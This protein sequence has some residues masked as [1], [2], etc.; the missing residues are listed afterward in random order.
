MRKLLNLAL[1]ALTIAAIFYCI[2]LGALYFE[3]RTYEQTYNRM[4][5]HG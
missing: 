5:H 2:L 1:A 4:H 3:V